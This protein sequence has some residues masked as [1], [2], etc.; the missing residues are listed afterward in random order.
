MALEL[1]T[2]SF[3]RPADTTAY[4][5]LDLVANSTTA[6][7]VAPMTFNF[8]K[9]VNRYL[10][11]INLSKS[12]VTVTN[13][14]F[15]VDFFS[16]APTYAGGDNAIVAV[17]GGLF[18]YRVDMPIMTAQTASANSCLYAGQLATFSQ[19][20]LVPDDAWVSLAALAA[21]TPG[22]GDVFTLTL[23]VSE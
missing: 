22:S 12:T 7:S 13:A 16:A 9:G 17:A 8:G 3:T 14:T 6:G 1:H 5:A 21:Y 2:A 18:M 4:A 19:P 20:L 23:G 10:H 11:S 15:R